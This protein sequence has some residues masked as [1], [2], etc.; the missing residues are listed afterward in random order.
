MA[1]NKF[2]LTVIEHGSRY[3]SGAFIAGVL[4]LFM[5]KYYTY[6]FGTEEYGVLALYLVM[7][8]YVRTFVSLNLEGGISRIYFDY[9]KT[10]RDEY[11]STIFWF[12][13]FMAVINLVL[14]L[15]AMPYVSD[16]I[17]PGSG[18]IYLITLFTGIGMVY[19][20]YLIRILL[21]E[22]QS[23]LV[24]RQTVSQSLLNHL[25]SFL[26]ITFMRLGI[27]GRMFGNFISFAIN[28]TS[29]L[30]TTFRNN[31]FKI[32]AKFNYQMAKETFLFAFPTLMSTMMNILF[33]YLDRI[34]IKYYRGNSEVGVYTLG[35]MLGHGF[36]IVNDSISK[37]I[38]PNVFKDMEENYDETKSALER[39]A[40]KYY[41]GLVVLTV[42]IAL[43]SP[44]IV[45][46]F[47]YHQYEKAALVLPFMLAGFMMGGLYKISALV[48]RYHKIVWFY[49]FLSIVAFGSNAI[50]NYLLIPMYGI[51]GAA[52][53]T[54]IG[55]FLYSIILQLLSL[56]YFNRKYNLITLLINISTLGATSIFYLIQINL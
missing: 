17:A 40:F 26:F 25:F 54:F 9:H 29:L 33:I 34:F 15:I 41:F 48:L 53:A 39:F 55:H 6:V 16:W 43:L 32:R 45:D 21:N 22:H 14:G 44:L 19:F 4:S 3:F 12:I 37:A 28:N 31:L 30:I 7:M 5:T 24:L 49:P 36:S 35:Y 23:T 42:T 52:Y 47:S 50:L 38:F 13:S 56:R 18:H 8:E 20:N 1:R 2:T 46:I 51:V 11:L 27:F 10:H